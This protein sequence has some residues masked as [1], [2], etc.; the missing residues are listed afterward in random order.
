M[1]CYVMSM[2]YKIVA[3]RMWKVKKEKSIMYRH[4][5]DVTG[6]RYC[7]IGRIFRGVRAPRLSEFALMCLALDVSADELLRADDAW[8]IIER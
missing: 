1:L 3:E 2:N 7:I 6:L 8:E 4:I 5:E